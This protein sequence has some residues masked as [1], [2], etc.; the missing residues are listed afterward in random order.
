VRTRPCD[1]LRPEPTF[2]SKETS[3]TS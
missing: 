2:S 1:R 3:S